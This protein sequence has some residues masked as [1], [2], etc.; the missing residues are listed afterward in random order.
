MTKV[1]LDIAV[2]F[3]FILHDIIYITDCGCVF[4]Q[5]LCAFSSMTK[6]LAL[7]TSFSQVN[8]W[9]YTRDNLQRYKSPAIKIV[10]E[11]FRYIMIFL[12]RLPTVS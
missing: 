12:Y 11:C 1:L 7:I 9:L 6:W 3:H 8:V 2:A 5:F 4:L 10:N